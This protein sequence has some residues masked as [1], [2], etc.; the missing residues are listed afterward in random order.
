ME[1]CRSTVYIL[2][3]EWDISAVYVGYGV[4]ARHNAMDNESPYAHLLAREG[5][6][7]DEFVC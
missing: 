3:L 6:I 1:C 2:S 7:G 4:P 5:D